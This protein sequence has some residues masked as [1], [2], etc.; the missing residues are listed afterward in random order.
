MSNRKQSHTQIQ[1]VLQSRETSK[2]TNFHNHNH[3]RTISYPSPQDLEERA[4]EINKIAESVSDISEIF[5]DLANLVNT[6]G[7]DIDNIEF[8]IEEAHENTRQ[9]TLD[10]AKAASYQRMNPLTKI[11]TIFSS[12]TIGTAIGGPLGLLAGFKAGCIATATVGAI[13]GGLA[14]KRYIEYSDSKLQDTIDETKEV[15]KRN[16]INLSK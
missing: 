3:A 10:L 13:T 11:F 16:Q 1:E 2:D 8:H 15:T 7:Q 6:Q 14:G 9:G 5:S 4:E 12:T